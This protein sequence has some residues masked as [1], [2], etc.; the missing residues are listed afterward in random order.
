MSER[1]SDKIMI[2]AIKS[3]RKRFESFLIW[4][5]HVYSKMICSD[6]GLPNPENCKEQN[7]RVAIPAK[8][9]FNKLFNEIFDKDISSMEVDCKI[10]TKEN[11]RIGNE[12]LWIWVES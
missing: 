4:Q 10:F 11:Y 2:G 3:N 12:I 9:N 6:F 1:K 5:A 8:N 7:Y